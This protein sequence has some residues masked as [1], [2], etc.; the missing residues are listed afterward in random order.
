MGAL[1]SAIGKRFME[2]S[3]SI[4]C[5]TFGK[6]EV[7]SLKAVQLVNSRKIVFLTANLFSLAFC[8]VMIRFLKTGWN[9]KGPCNSE[10]KKAG[11]EIWL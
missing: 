4:A 1:S 10:A 6:D 9:M 3:V 8:L 7:V 11:D 5:D 2:K